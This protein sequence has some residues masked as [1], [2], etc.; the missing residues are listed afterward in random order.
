MR[1]GWEKMNA[2]V[3]DADIRFVYAHASRFDQFE[4]ADGH[5]TGTGPETT[6]FGSI[7]LTGWDEVW[8][9]GARVSI[10]PLQR[11][12]RTYRHPGHGDSGDHAQTL[13][14]HAAYRSAVRA[15]L[16]RAPALAMLRAVA[17]QTDAR[18]T[19]VPCPLISDSVTADNGGWRA[20]SR[21]PDAARIRQDF[22]D[23]IAA[24]LPA[25][26]TVWRQ[27]P[28]LCATPITTP[29]QFLRGDDLHHMNAAFGARILAQL[30]RSTVKKS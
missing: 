19:C 28:S 4:V 22:A 3:A 21:G 15:A 7:A 5:L 13:I 18:L 10:G 30:L 20:S 14:S 25:S 6:R 2:N 29:L 24:H 11:L 23:A 16:A 17:R 27:P 26:V 9:V 8:V 1:E 12:Y